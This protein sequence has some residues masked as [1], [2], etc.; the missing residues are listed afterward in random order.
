MQIRGLFGFINMPAYQ[1]Q[2]NRE[3][4]CSGSLLLKKIRPTRRWRSDCGLPRRI[5]ALQ[6]DITQLSVDAIVNAAHESLEVGGGVNGAIHRAAGPEWLAE[7]RKLGKCKEGDAKITKGGRLSA[8]F[9][10]HTVGPIWAGGAYCEAELLASCYRRSLEV[11]VEHG[12]RSVAFP[13]VSTGVHGHDVKA[14][15]TIAVTTVSS[16][17]AREAS[18][19]EVIFCCFLAEDFAVYE[20]ILEQAPA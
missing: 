17:L 15:A 1:W 16:F 6:G 2:F 3:K 11:A 14:A 8:K 9:V 13:G 4:L 7:C 18:I 12:V 5:R 10:I 19:R 20:R